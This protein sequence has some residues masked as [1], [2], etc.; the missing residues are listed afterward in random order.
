MLEH[1]REKQPSCLLGR[2]T[3]FGGDE[4]YHRAKLIHHHHDHIKSS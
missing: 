1:M 3:F 4:M 2:G